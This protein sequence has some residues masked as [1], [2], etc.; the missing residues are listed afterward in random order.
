MYT[1]TYP[2]LKTILCWYLGTG[3]REPSVNS[4]LVPSKIAFYYL[5]RMPKIIEIGR[6]FH[7]EK[8]KSKT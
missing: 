6:I 2:A 8:R 5:L 1:V 4:F 7:S 3:S